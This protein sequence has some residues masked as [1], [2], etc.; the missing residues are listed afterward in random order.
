MPDKIEFFS[1]IPEIV[2]RKRASCKLHKSQSK[3]IGKQ[4]ATVWTFVNNLSM[5]PEDKAFHVSVVD[6]Q[7]QTDIVVDLP[8]VPWMDCEVSICPIHKIF[9]GALTR[10]WEK[11][12]EPLHAEHEPWSE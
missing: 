8:F 7:A 6:V 11:K 1:D 10:E 4:L 2:I 3:I 5:I 9:R 12:M